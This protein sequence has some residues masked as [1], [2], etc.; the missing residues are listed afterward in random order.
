MVR[1]LG[2]KIFEA[3]TS[4]VASPQ[5][6]VRGVFRDYRIKAGNMRTYEPRVP[7][8]FANAW[9]IVQQQLK[10]QE[11]EIARLK[12]DRALPKTKSTR[13]ACAAPKA[14]QQSDQR[15]LLERIVRL[16]Q[17]AIDFIV[18]GRTTS[19]LQTLL[20]LDHELDLVVGE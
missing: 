8:E 19:G 12:A 16:N 7:A 18:E 14:E 3:E 10:D 13:N 20:R 15:A 2:F 17:Q 1:V 4:R 5:S 9:Q 11:A 6:F